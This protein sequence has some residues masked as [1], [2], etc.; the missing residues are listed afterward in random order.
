VTTNTEAG[1]I[2]A[3]VAEAHHKA[4]VIVLLLAA[5]VIVYTVIGLVLVNAHEPRILSS[6]VPIPFY[7]AA[8]F[9]A[10]GS[11][12]VRRAQLRPL[13]LEVVA[14]LRGIGGLVNHFL[15]IAVVSAALAEIIGVLALVVVFFGGNQSDVLRLGIVALAVTLYAYPRRAAWQKAV[16]YYAATMP[17]VA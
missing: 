4:K 1:N 13:R 16:E 6:Q 2:Q 7:V 17:G 3:R 8:V 10:L 9:L 5:S 11:I 15:Q 14:G 12:A